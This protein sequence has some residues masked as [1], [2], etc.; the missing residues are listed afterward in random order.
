MDNENTTTGANPVQDYAEI[1]HQNRVELLVTESDELNAIYQRQA[2]AVA[3]EDQSVLKECEIAK[4]PLLASIAQRM[5]D[6]IEGQAPYVSEAR[7]EDY[8]ACAAWLR[9]TAKMSFASNAE[10]EQFKAIVGV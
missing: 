6:R 10:R 4:S 5:A 3:A 1:L 7:R 2:E 8:V 9:K